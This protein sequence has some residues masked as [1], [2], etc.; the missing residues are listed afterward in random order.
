[1][2]PKR[3]AVSEAGEAVGDTMGCPAVKVLAVPVVP[4]IQNVVVWLEP[5][6]GDLLTKKNWK[7]TSELTVDF[8]DLMFGCW[9]PAA[10]R[11][12]FAA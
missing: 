6:V 7:A 12:C 3:L 1:M 5:F 11:R 4:L 9:S 8:L 2:Q 10:C